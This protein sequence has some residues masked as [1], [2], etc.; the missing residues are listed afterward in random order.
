MWSTHSPQH[1]QFA[2][3]CTIIFC[4][5]A[6]APIGLTAWVAVTGT[7]VTCSLDGATVAALLATGSGARAQAVID[8][9]EPHA[10]AAIQRNLMFIGDASLGVNGSGR[11]EWA[12]CAGVR[13]SCRTRGSP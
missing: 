8:M 11:P 2:L 4:A 9:S 6:L 12:R 13:R 5:F 3:L 1:P 10:A 7:A